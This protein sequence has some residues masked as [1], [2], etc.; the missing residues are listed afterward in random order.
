MIR[1]MLKAVAIMVTLKKMLSF[2]EMKLRNIMK[3]SMLKIKTCNK[4]LKLLI[5]TKPPIRPEI[6]SKPNSNKSLK[7]EN[8]S[9]L[10]GAPI[11]K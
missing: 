5:K 7:K 8:F 3:Y 11:G 2:S 4:P 10:L 9:C 1:L 6:P